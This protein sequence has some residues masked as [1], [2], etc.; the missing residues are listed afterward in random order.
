MKKLFLFFVS[1]LSAGIISAQTVSP[2][3]I[4]SSGGSHG[5]A[6]ASVSW[7]L[8]ECLAETFSGSGA[9]INQGMQQGYLTVTA[10]E[11]VTGEE[12]GLDIYPVPADHYINLKI[13]GS[14]DIDLNVTLSDLSGNMLIIRS[15]TD[16]ACR[17]NLESL[18]PAEYILQITDNKGRLIKSFSI[19]KH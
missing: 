6:A 10:L 1:L 8:G 18:P 7:T 5:N 9:V 3:V 16:P 19:I 13:T 11:E 4:A 17:I 12:Y 14:C 15:V 2:E